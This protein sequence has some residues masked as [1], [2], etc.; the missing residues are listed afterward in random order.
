MAGCWGT[1]RALRGTVLEVSFVRY[2]ALSDARNLNQTSQPI[3][4]L[5]QSIF[6]SSTPDACAA[7]H[8]FAVAIRKVSSP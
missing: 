8:R 1:A 4:P 3:R 5:F 2:L 7:K 6:A